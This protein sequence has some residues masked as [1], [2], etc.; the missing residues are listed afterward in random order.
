VKKIK[1]FLG[2]IC[3]KCKK[4]FEADNQAQH[5]CRKCLNRKIT[6]AIESRYK[7]V[8]PIFHTK[9]IVCGKIFNTYDYKQ[10]CC[11]PECRNVL[12]QIRKYKEYTAI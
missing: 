12:K 4:S 9:C 11:S 1:K 3:T 6:A 8:K 10:K 7:E 5:L 2:R